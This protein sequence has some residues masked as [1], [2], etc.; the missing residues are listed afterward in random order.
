MWINYIKIKM[1]ALSLFSTAFVCFIIVASINYVKAV[2]TLTVDCQDKIRQ[3]THCAS[4]SLY[5]LIENKPADFDKFVA[6]LHP[7]AF[8]NPARSGNGR[9]Q[10]IGDAIKVGQ[11]LAGSPGAK[12]SI[13]LADIL[14]GW[15]YRWPNMDSWLNEVK[16]VIRDK[17][18]AGLNNVYGYEI[19]NEPDGTWKNPSGVNFNQ[20]WK[21]T[22]DTIRQ[23]DPNEKIIGPCYSWYR[24]NDLKSFL[25]FTIANNCVPDI[26]CWHELSGIE[27]V[28]SH[29]RSYRNMEKS[30]GLKELP[31]SINEYC[32]ASHDL[33]GQPGS[34]ARFIGKFERYKID[35]GM[36]TWWFVP[37]PGRLGSLMAS[38]NQPGAGWF[39]YK[40][41]GDMNGDM[42]QVKPPNDDSKFIDGAACVNS[43]EGY[44]SF[45]LGG[46]N[47]GSVNAEFKNIPN[48]IG[49][50]ANVKVEKVDWTS[51]DTPSNGPVT[52]SENKV[53]VNNGQLSVN[54]PNTNGNSGYR[55]YI[56]KG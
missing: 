6:P 3:A 23:N 10:P 8:N 43:G 33:E 56:T 45:I 49:S 1:K 37:L 51:K 7:F 18:S 44:I 50:T 35:S 26:V 52:I 46:P 32:D 48:F 55:I 16:S 29:F 21:Q 34:S 38:D 9:Q 15:P 47:D 54:I 17:K 4:G 25:Q 24:E 40:W 30:L 53:A 41:Y 22:Y 28:S 12:V 42:V 5:G 19:W 14:P 11:R 13:R 36:I 31:I 20:L 2:S 39:L 27:G